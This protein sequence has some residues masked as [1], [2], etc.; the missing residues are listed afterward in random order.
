MAKWA[1]R[2]ATMPGA[3]LSG[4]IVCIGGITTITGATDPK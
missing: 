1:V 2:N 4:F 3:Q